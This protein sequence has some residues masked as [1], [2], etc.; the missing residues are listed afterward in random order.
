MHT[1]EWLDH[2][3]TVQGLTQDQVP[4]PRILNRIP[5]C[6]ALLDTSKRVVFINRFMEALLGVTLEQVAGLPCQHVV[7]GNM[8][9]SRCPLKIMS[10][11]SESVCR[12]GDIIDR[13]RERIPVR[14]TFAPVQDMEGNLAGWLECFEDLRA[15]KELEETRSTAYSFGPL[16]GHS[17]QIEA[18]FRMVPGVAQTD[19]SVLITGETGTGKDILAEVIHQQSERAKGPF[20]KVNCGALPESLLESELFG[21]QKGAFTGAT[22]NKPG[23]FKLAHL[24][25]LFLTEIGDLP[26]PLQVKLLSFLD[27]QVIY[28]LGST[29][30]VQVDVRV[31]A[32]TNR[33]LQSMVKEGEFREDLL[34]R[35]NV[36]RLHLPPLREREGDVR[37]LLDHFLQVF[38]NKFRKQLSGFSEECLGIL[39]NYAYPGN[40][41][42]LKNIIEFAVNVCQGSEIEV[43]N[44]PSYI[45][46]AVEQPLEAQE[47][48]GAQAAGPA[49]IQPSS[50]QSWPEVERQ[51]ILKALVQAKGRKS[52]AAKLLGWGRST[53][54]RKMK[55]YEIEG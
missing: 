15:H 9:A 26:K 54:W 35:L 33:D 49:P 7:R 37:L 4:L 47:H 10:P 30:G 21:H 14:I 3:L 24:G 20:V 32:A 36:V 34:F 41:R 23:R 18:L 39:L 1:S 51:M 27:D 25:S 11:D 12:E 5:F 6:V 28:P 44:L 45:F 38:M 31:I 29:K 53:L 40:V 22:A 19:S 42:E 17:R 2:P 43:G 16:L 50:E 55:Q 46:Q 52:V 13:S 8:C 48:E